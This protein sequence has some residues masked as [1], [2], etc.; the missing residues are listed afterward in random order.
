MLKT[1]KF[2]TKKEE[3]KMDNIIDL[4]EKLFS[5]GRSL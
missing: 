2:S 1:Y 5:I 3:I 4:K